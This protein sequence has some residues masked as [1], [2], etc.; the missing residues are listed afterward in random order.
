M[1]AY[2]HVGD[3][4]LH[5]SEAMQCNAAATANLFQAYRDF[6]K[7]IYISTSEVYGYQTSVPF[8]E[9]MTPFPIS[10]YAVGKYSGELYAKMMH[11]V[12]NLPLQ[13]YGLLT[14]LGHIRAPG[15]SSGRLSSNVF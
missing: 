7:L 1:A 13:L 12:Y 3:S 2:N 14:H 6:G 10:P 4:F 5:V 9:E 15:R 11:H 8:H